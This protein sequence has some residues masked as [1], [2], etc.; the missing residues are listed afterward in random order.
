MFG[1]DM[2]I[3][4]WPS[5]PSLAPAAP[6][7]GYRRRLLDHHGT[8]P[9]DGGAMLVWDAYS[10]GMFPMRDDMLMEEVC[11]C[12]Q[13]VSQCGRKFTAPCPEFTNRTDVVP[14]AN[15]ALK[16]AQCEVFTGPDPRKARFGRIN[17]SPA[18]DATYGWDNTGVDAGGH[19][20]GYWF[21]FTR[22]AANLTHPDLC[23]HPIDADPATGYIPVIAAHEC[24]HADFEYN[25]SMP[26]DRG[27]GMLNWGDG[28]TKE[29]STTDV[30]TY[31]YM[32]GTAM[33]TVWAGTTMF[34]GII[35]RYF[36]HK[37]W[38]FRAHQV[39]STQF[40]HHA[41][42]G[43]RLPHTTQHAVR[44]YCTVLRRRSNSYCARRTA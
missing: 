27:T 9:A 28:T 34:G 3:G 11:K 19:K 25:P 17:I 39:S 7:P 23:D 18:N 20:G 13:A 29:W 8:K 14:G 40:T 32:H 21:Q 24:S 33:A 5:S 38:W 15:K 42:C 36:R 4:T 37:W 31:R 1:T 41:R 44:V 2:I 43:T 10:S 6:T 30:R 16:E 26:L 22:G 12:T 35:A